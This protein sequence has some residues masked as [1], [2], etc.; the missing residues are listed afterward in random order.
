LDCRKR[1]RRIKLKGDQLKIVIFFFFSFSKL[2]FNYLEN[3]KNSYFY[4]KDRSKKWYLS[5]FLEIDDRVLCFGLPDST[6]TSSVSG[7]S[8][9][10]NLV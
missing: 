3:T 7:Y 9:Y 2:I 10:R 6:T 5:S 8:Y 4:D 1:L